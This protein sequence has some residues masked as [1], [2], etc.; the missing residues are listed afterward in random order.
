MRPHFLGSCNPL[1]TIW[2]GNELDLSWLHMQFLSTL[3]TT[4]Q[5]CLV[6]GGGRAP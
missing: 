1:L 6:G 2:A 4:V 3:L 5:H